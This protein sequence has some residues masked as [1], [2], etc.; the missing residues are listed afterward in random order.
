MYTT[1]KKS[2]LEKA[3][4]Q[5]VRVVQAHASI[6]ALQGIYC[7]AQNGT[8]T[9]RSTNLDIGIEITLPASVEEKGECLVP[10]KIF[11]DTVKFSP[12]GDISL[13]SSESTLTLVSKRG[14]ARITLL[15]HSDFPSIPRHTTETE[16]IIDPTILISGLQSVLFS[17]SPSTIKPELGCVSIS[18]F[19]TSLICVSTD[20]FRLSEKKI[21]YL[22]DENIPP[23]LLP[24]KNTTELLNILSSTSE[25]SVSLFVEEDQLSVQAGTLYATFRLVTGTFPEYQKI[26]PKEFVATVKVLRQ[27]VEIALKKASVFL[28]MNKQI[29]LTLAP[30]EN[31]MVLSSKSSTHGDM[32]ESIPCTIEGEALTLAFNHRYFM[33]GITAF[34]DEHLTLS[35]SGSKRPLIIKGVQ[36]GTYLYLVMPMNV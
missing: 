35:F 24:Q 31:S 30:N 4:A 13:K 10:A 17:V 25:K 2:V 21:P 32:E 33:E 36:D 20:S 23:I 7:V 5:N 6:P 15:P 1:L 28:E 26:I 27:D 16:V 18:H 14:E 34:K 22:G 19:D 3:L 8:L 29:T 9:L 12:D 11:L